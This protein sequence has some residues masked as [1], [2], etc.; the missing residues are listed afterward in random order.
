MAPRI[1]RPYWFR[2]TGARVPWAAVAKAQYASAAATPWWDKLS[3]DLP[4]IDDSRT[5]DLQLRWQCKAELGVP[6][7]PFTVWTRAPK[8]ALKEVDVT[9][10]QRSEGLSLRLP[11]VAAVIAVQCDVIDPTR[12]VGLVATY[13][14]G[15]LREAVGATAVSAPGGGRITLRVRC[16]G[17][18]RVLLVNGTNPTVGILPLQDVLDDPGWK[19]MERVGLPVDDPWPGTGYDT[20][21]QGLVTAPTDPVSAA[22]ERLKRGGP[23]VGWAP[24]TGS[25]RLAPSWRAPDYPTLLKEIQQDL[26]PRI[27]RLYRPGRAPADQATM[28]DS[29]TVD[30]PSVGSKKS[31]LATTATLAPL[32]LLALPSSADP[33]LALAT[34][35]GTAYPVVG[36]QRRG[37]DVLVTA[38][39]PDTPWKDGPVVMA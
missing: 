27:E 37:V 2:A 10:R 15:G 4:R 9:I 8:D 21:Q 14:G 38:E 5:A 7:G 32:S 1:A 19:E 39:Y 6:F 34:G 23:P 18:T 17:A 29:P 25:G 3:H 20:S 13:V 12:A 26:L 33:F 30:P 16:S 24:V 22:L 28:A 11:V 36:E 31:S 35:F